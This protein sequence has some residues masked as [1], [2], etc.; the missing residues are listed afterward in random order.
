IALHVF[1]CIL[2]IIAVLLQQGQGSD[3]ASIFGGG[4]GAS[5]IMSGRTAMSLLNKITVACFILFIGTSLAISIL[6][7][8]RA[9]MRPPI[10]SVPP[11]STAPAVPSPTP[12]APAP[13]K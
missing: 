9:E 8:R 6:Q 10:P 12:P 5:P 13:Q 11:A 2:I 4:S 3:L 7:R 1:L